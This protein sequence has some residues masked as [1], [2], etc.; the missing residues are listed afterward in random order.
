MQSCPWTTLLHVQPNPT[1]SAAA[2]MALALTQAACDPPRPAQAAADISADGVALPW[3]LPSPSTSMVIPRDLRAPATPGARLD[4]AARWLSNALHEAGYRAL[5]YYDVPGGF[6]VLCGLEL[7]DDHGLGLTPP[8]PSLRFSRN[9]PQGR[10]LSLS[11]WSQLLAGQRGHYRL[12]TFVVI[13]D[14]FDYA[15][16]VTDGHLLWRKPSRALP[17]VRAEMPYDGHEGWY[18]VIYEVEKTANAQSAKLA[19]H[20]VNPSVN[21]AKSGILAALEHEARSRESRAQEA[22][23]R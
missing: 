3:P 10:F 23:P 18:A 1:G 7:V 8:D 2:T 13:D 17:L 15:M 6:V 9:L 20:P 14:V 12:M 21:L 5:T 11:F 22:T 16:D 19:S 4:V